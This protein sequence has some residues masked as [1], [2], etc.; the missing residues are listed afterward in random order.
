M[1]WGK[2]LVHL[3]KKKM[4]LPSE[5][6]KTLALRLVSMSHASYNLF[7]FTSPQPPPL[8]GQG[9]PVHADVLSPDGHGAFRNS[10]W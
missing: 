2:Y 8:A 3:K 9:G 7:L 10:S 4:R 1:A 6:M 5:N